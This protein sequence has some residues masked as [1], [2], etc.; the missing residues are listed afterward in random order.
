MPQMALVYTDKFALT[1]FH[2]STSVLEQES[3]VDPHQVELSPVMTATHDSYNG[4][5]QKSLSV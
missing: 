5:G 2:L 1:H 4:F 3:R